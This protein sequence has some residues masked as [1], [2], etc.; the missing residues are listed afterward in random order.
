MS[1]IVYN[2]TY[3]SVTPTLA[4][5]Q[6]VVTDLVT[7]D[8]NAGSYDYKLEI[9]CDINSCLDDFTYQRDLSAHTHTA[10]G[11]ANA[12]ADLHALVST[13]TSTN[14][15][16]IV[17][18]SFLTTFSD[19][20]TVATASWDHFWGGLLS[21]CIDSDDKDGLSVMM[22]TLQTRIDYPTNLGSYVD[23]AAADAASYINDVT[24]GI[25]DA[26]GA[27][28]T[29]GAAGALSISDVAFGTGTIETAPAS[30][31]NFLVAAALLFYHTLGATVAG[32]EGSLTGDPSDG[33]VKFALGPGNGF[34]IRISS[35]I[36]NARTGLITITQSV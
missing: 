23:V 13:G 6:H 20:D 24:G 14:T 36:T 15:T 32:T 19:G 12:W 16:P 35:T 2:N 25:N 8:P 30:A 27:T 10:A 11:E 1:T 4:T 29:T 34:G 22:T 26:F 21:E 31:S 33:A 28:A 3:F 18:D 7:T 9:V 17:A 5:Y